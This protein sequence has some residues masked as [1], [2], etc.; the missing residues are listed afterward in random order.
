MKR[1]SSFE[2]VRL[3]LRSASFHVPTPEGSPFVFQITAA[4]GT[5]LAIGVQR[6]GDPVGVAVMADDGA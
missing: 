1:T 3:I 5:I 4:F 2:G 6:E